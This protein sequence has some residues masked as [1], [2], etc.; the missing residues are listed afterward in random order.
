MWAHLIA[1]CSRFARPSAGPRRSDWYR[2]QRVLLLVLGGNRFSKLGMPDQQPP[3]VGVSMTEEKVG[4][5]SR[6]HAR[7][8]PWFLWW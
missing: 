5:C 4:S 7:S 8:S 1:C 2:P 6:R 3:A